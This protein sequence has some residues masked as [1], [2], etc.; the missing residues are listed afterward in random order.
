M[1]LDLVIRRAASVS[2]IIFFM[3]TL[4][5]RIVWRLP[6]KIV[7]ASRNVVWKLVSIGIRLSL[8]LGIWFSGTLE[9]IN[10]GIVIPQKVKFI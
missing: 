4:E 5:S 10:S 7:S 1:Y 3:A 9:T 8:S 6:L 2:G